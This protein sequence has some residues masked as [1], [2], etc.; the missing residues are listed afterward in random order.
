MPANVSGQ[1]APASRTRSGPICQQSRTDLSTSVSD[2]LP[3]GARSAAAIKARICASGTGKDRAPAPS[4][5]TRG[6]GASSLPWAQKSPGRSTASN[7]FSITL[8]MLP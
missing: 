5:C 2:P 1:A 7:S 6:I 4:T 8:S 3:Y